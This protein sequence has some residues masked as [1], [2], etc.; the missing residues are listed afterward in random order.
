MSCFPPFRPPC[1]PPSSLSSSFLFHCSLTLAPFCASSSVRLP[2]S[3][4]PVRTAAPAYPARLFVILSPCPSVSP[5]RYTT[6]DAF[7]VHLSDA[8]PLHP[9][10]PP[11]THTYTCP[12]ARTHAR[13]HARSRNTTVLPLA[14]ARGDVRVRSPQERPAAQNHMV[15]PTD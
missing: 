5:S 13:T 11:H 8:G 1:F 4:F 9:P 14:R 3:T 6:G 15:R 12:R 10:T 7:P 2:R